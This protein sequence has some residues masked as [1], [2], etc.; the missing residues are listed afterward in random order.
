MTN[1]LLA[2]SPLDGRYAAKVLPLRNYFSEF[3][4]FKYR[5]LVEVKYFI[6]LLDFLPDCQGCTDEEK[7]WLIEIVDSFDLNEAEKV[8]NIEKTTNHD[9]KA[10][11]YYLKNKLAGTPLEMHTEMVHFGLTSQDVNNTAIPLSIKEAL[12]QSIFPEIEALL[13]DIF[14]LGESNLHLPMLA[15]THGQAASP[16][17]LGKEMMV[18]YERLS[19]QFSL[20]KSIALEGK[21]GGATGNFNAHY[22][23]YPTLDW[24]AFADE[25]LQKDLGLIRQ[26]TTTQIE[27]YDQLANLLHN[28]IRIQQILIDFCRDIWH[29]I[30]IDYFRQK[31]IPGEVGSSAM[32]HKVNPIDFENAEGNLGLS[33]AIAE[34]LAIKLPVS[35]L[36]RDLTD[37]T[38][39]RNIGLPFAHFL[40]SCQALRK[41]IGK[42]EVN[43]EAIY[44][45]LDD[46]AIILSE[47]IQSVLRSIRYRAPYEKL[48]ELTRGKAHLDINDILKFIENLDIDEVTKCHLRQLRPQNYTGNALKINPE[49]WKK[50]I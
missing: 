32:P 17:G 49:N 42:L 6:A 39:L 40:I 24:P 14:V 23:A 18:F 35:R 28:L 8:K 21:F 7:N 4:L 2:L 9:V 50:T 12:H 11:E 13:N 31:T 25:F 43:H 41:G 45:D 20:F 16:T 22:A 15:R 27:H 1:P 34:H 48:K 47:A 37:S 3:A 38:V 10:V 29:Y 33:T 30:S 26:K 19:K 44:K 46:H 36:Q 5:L